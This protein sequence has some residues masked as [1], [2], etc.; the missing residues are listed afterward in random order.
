MRILFCFSLILSFL[1]SGSQPLFTL[2]G[3]ITNTSSVP[4]P[5]TSVYLL[6][7]NRG[8]LSDEKGYF[9]LKNLLPGKYTVQF[10]S[11]G[12][13]TTDMDLMLDEN[14]NAPVNIQLTE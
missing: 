11:I 3:K 4:L 1:V 12:Y 8:T 10:S 5:G 6:N 14:A 13:A 7:T 9:E 2:S